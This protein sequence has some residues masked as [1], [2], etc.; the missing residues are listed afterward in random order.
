M[1][2]L[3]SAQ[4]RRVSR[5]TQERLTQKK[6]SWVVSQPPSNTDTEL[7]DDR[8]KGSDECRCPV[9]PESRFGPAQVIALH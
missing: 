7:K 5:N 3:A 2:L 1:W 6:T 9:A 4:G 8:G